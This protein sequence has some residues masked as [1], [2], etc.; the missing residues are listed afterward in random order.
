[1]KT[2]NF[3]IDDLRTILHLLGVAVWV[4]GQI[5]M[6]G[7]LPVLRKLGADAPKQAAAGFGRVA[8]PAFGL[9]IVTGIWNMLSVDMASVSTG[10]NIAFGLKLLLVMI[11][12]FAAFVHQRTATPALKGITGALGLIASLAALAVGVAMAH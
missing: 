11:T 12:G 4:G 5:L 1:M 2:I 3:G 9:V 10:Y 8:W 7:L 6:L